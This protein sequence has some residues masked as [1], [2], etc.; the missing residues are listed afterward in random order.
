MGV[1]SLWGTIHSALETVL[2]VNQK[3]NE[4]IISSGDLHPETYSN[5]NQ[6]VHM[7]TSKELKAFLEEF[8]IRIE[9]MSSCNSLSAGYGS[10]LEPVENDRSKWSY[11]LE[12]EI[13][14]SREDGFLD[15][16]SHM[17]AV[18]RKL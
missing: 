1:M 6:R 17:I 7:F 10:R 4:Q 18:I 9:C 16:G 5:P 3:E 15:G 14:S 8:D 13:V 2:S 12:K 11:L